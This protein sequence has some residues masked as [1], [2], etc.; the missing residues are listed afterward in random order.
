MEILNLE[1]KGAI[2]LLVSKLGKTV[3]SIF[4]NTDSPGLNTNQIT[5]WQFIEQSKL[6]STSKLIIGK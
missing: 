6:R 5:L 3:S 2:E 4:R 1:N